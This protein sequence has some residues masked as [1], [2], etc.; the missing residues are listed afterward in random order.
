MARSLRRRARLGGKFSRRQK[1]VRLSVRAPLVASLFL[2]LSAAAHAQF[3]EADALLQAAVEE[4]RVPRVVA[5]ALNS[6]DIVY[7]GAFGKRNVAADADM[8]G[9]SIYR[10]ASMTKPITTVAVMQLVEKGLIALDDPAER[11]VPALA[12]VKVLT[13]FDTQ[14]GEQFLREP[15]TAITVRQLLTHTSGFA[16]AMFDGDIQRLVA[17]GVLGT[18]AED[19]PGFLAAPLIF[20]PG[21]RWEYGIS[22]D[23]LGQLVERVT[24]QTLGA[25]FREHIFVPLGMKDTFFNPP[26]D[27]G[28][29]IVRFHLRA[30][31][32]ELVE[33]DQPP[34]AVTFFSGGGGLLSTA[35][36]YAQIMG[37]LLNNGSLNGTSVLQPATVAT[38][39]QNHIGA[40]EAGAEAT[41]APQ[42]SR[43][44]RLLPAV[45][46]QVRAWIPNQH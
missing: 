14:T 4:G 12:D 23:W 19:S 15:A 27:R 25:Y 41:V 8:T 37:M 34:Q 46:R 17:D 38:M 31:T 16:Y 5:L 45:R 7:E 42:L 33:Q 29:R 2:L 3:E 18:A 30:P 6:N 35:R 24:G 26:S 22:T 39:A 9:D 40:L 21:E 28:Q 36:D 44:L 11:H 1:E 10:I 13:G 43:R 32:G 20:D